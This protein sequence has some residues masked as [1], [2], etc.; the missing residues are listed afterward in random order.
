MGGG[1]SLLRSKCRRDSECW[2]RKGTHGR[3]TPSS[4]GFS[5]FPVSLHSHF[6]LFPHRRPGSQSPSLPLHG[7]GGKFKKF[8]RGIK[9]LLSDGQSL[10]SGRAS[11]PSQMSFPSPGTRARARTHTHTPHL[12]RSGASVSTSLHLCTDLCFSLRAIC[13]WL[14]YKSCCVSL[15]YGIINYFKAQRT[16]LLLG[17]GASWLTEERF[18]VMGHGLATVPCHPAPTAGAELAEAPVPRGSIWQ[19]LGGGHAPAVTR[20]AFIENKATH[21]L[22]P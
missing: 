8:H 21:H 20:M 22:S 14:C 7:E 2:S 5:H 18:A 17:L 6:S 11:A 9:Y 1:G 16:P 10:K 19:Q 12:P 3:R 13:H 15:P 4:P